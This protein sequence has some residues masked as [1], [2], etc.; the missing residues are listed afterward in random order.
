MRRLGYLAFSAATL[1]LAACGQGSTNLSGGVGGSGG[2]TVDGTVV[3]SRAAIVATDVDSDG[4]A[5][6]VGV[7]REGLGASKCCLAF[8]SGARP[9]RTSFALGHSRV[10]SALRP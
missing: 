2:L 9:R 7:D 5:D 1:A 6:L 10:S 8:D 4:R 3:T